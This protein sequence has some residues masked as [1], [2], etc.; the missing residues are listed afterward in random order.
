MARFL[1]G[2]W[3]PLQAGVFALV[4]AGALLSFAPV[5][6]LAS[7]F[8]SSL[9][10]QRVQAVNV[11]LSNFVGPTA[12][13]TL[14][15]MVGQM[16]SDKVTTTV[17]EADQAASDRAA[18]SQL[19]G[20]PVQLL[21]ARKDEPTLTVSGRHAFN[22]AVDRSRLQA[23]LSEAGR[24]DLVVPQSVDGAAVA[25]RLPHT[26]RAQY[27]RCPGPT[28]AAANV[29]TPAPAST[30]YDDCVVLSQGL[31]PA[32]DAPPALDVEQL[33]QIGLELAG[34]NSE[35][36][37]TFLQTV[38]WQSTL[39]VSVPRSV[40]SYESVQVDGATGT[41]LNTAGRRGPTYALIWAKSGMVYSVVGFGNS[42][43]ALALAGSL[44]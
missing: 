10:V 32:V 40:R 23:I 13:P 37:H 22:L 12:N 38:N 14:Q 29:V 41:L 21:S 18:A 17:N 20:F 6:S 30:E 44:K 25:V 42:G 2:R 4:I 11:D 34:M 43:G 15:Q 26:V 33:V 35:Q 27:G 19:A 9:R 16:I 39:G 24:P 3:F 7:N 28:S 5:R 36:S 31:S 1:D 8:L